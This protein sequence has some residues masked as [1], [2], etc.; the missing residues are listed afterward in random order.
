MSNIYVCKLKGWLFLFDSYLNKLMDK[1]IASKLLS[2]VTFAENCMC[3]I[4][5]FAQRTCFFF[6]F[7]RLSSQ[8]LREYFFT[9]FT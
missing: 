2:V 8:F 5:F 7:D 4:T 9:I 1:T 6:C 3:T